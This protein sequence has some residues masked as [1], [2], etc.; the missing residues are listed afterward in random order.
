MGVQEDF[1]KKNQI[2]KVALEA[3]QHLE[4]EGKIMIYTPEKVAETN[5]VNI[6]RKEYA[7]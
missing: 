5:L 7:T 1:T 6:L 2:F 4:A 3:L